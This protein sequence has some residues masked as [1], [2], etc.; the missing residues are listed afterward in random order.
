MI[1]ET[2]RYRDNKM[3]EREVTEKKKVKREWRNT[4]FFYL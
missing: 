1:R 2:E 4:R 3:V